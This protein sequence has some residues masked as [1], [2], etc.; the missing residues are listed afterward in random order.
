MSRKGTS[1]SLSPSSSSPLLSCLD[2]STT[3]L[4]TGLSV[5][6]S[7]SATIHGWEVNLSVENSLVWAY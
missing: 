6:A 7:I 5:D 1:L 2:E 3:L 4:V